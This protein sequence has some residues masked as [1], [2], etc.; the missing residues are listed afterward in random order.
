[1]TTSLLGLTVLLAALAAQSP[2][3]PA[4]P[5]PAAPRAP[6]I[7]QDKPDWSKKAYDQLFKERIRELERQQAPPRLEWKGD[8]E[9]PRQISVECGTIV[10]RSNIDVDPRMIVRA[11]ENHG[12]K[13]RTV[14]MPDCK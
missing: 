5:V 8:A 2:A 9:A 4:P 7:N 14:P 3:I 12:S 13:I 10:L 6:E 1:M 11:P